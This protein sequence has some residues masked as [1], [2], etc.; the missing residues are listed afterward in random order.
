MP[1]LPTYSAGVNHD[2]TLNAPETRWGGIMRKIETSDFETSNIEFIEFWLMDPFIYD[3]SGPTIVE[4][5]FI[6]TW[7][8]F[9]KIF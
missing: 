5:I 6:S 7:E 8:I 3:T 9:R 4:V 2:G 1:I